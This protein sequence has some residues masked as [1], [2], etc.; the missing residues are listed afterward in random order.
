LSHINQFNAKYR[1]DLDYNIFYG[2]L[3]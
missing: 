3:L 1:L 2:Q